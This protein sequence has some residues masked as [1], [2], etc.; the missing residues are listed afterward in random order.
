MSKCRRW[1]AKL[2]VLVSVLLAATALLAGCGLFGGGDDPSGSEQGT[3]APPI[4]RYEGEMSKAVPYVFTTNRE[5]A[6]TFNGM[7][8]EQ[9]MKRILDELDTYKMK[10][11]FFLPGMRVAEEPDI[12]RE[13][14]SRGHA[15]E[16]N[17]LN[18]LDMLKLGYEQLYKE[19]HLSNEVIQKETGVT[20]RYIRTRSGDYN[21]DVRLAA[22][23]SG[24]D[25][26]VSYSL[27][28]SGWNSE[29][30]EEVYTYIQRH[31]TRGGI[32]ALDA[33][34]PQVL[35]TIPLIA[36]AAADVKY[37]LVMLSELMEHG[38]ERK[39]LEEI[40]GYDAAQFNED[41]EGTP[42][43][44][45]DSGDT[46]TKEIALTFDDW[47]SDFTVTKILDVLDS[48]N[49]K[50]SFFLRANGVENNPNLAR[51]IAE[52][53]HDVGN[54]TY[55]HPVITTLTPQQLQEEVVK[56]HQVITEAIQ[57]KPAMLLRPPT[58]AFDEKTAQIVA[59]TG[60]KTIAMYNVTTLDWDVSHDAEFIEK[61]IMDETKS[62]SVILLHMLDG[63]HT[64]EALPVV[65]EKLQSKGYTFVPMSELLKHTDQ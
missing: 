12:A 32:I 46:N 2:F 43:K 24:M 20:P 50:A 35:K 62:G 40:P 53:G 7:S 29:N 30:E 39:P 17:T 21:D 11:T 59:A 5:L 28:L 49:I 33:E 63:L 54:H 4:V 37:K 16:N 27:N 3:T 22:A 6:L 18:R 57:R 25:S 42:Y 64:L 65:I 60:Y 44:V 41:Y 15:I 31:V 34:G 47:G 61:I 58:G 14:V 36:E 48:Y 13:I 8:D 45:I 55:T 38:T 9:T 51:A 19:I 52:A 10:A 1:P 26:V 56:A 23:H